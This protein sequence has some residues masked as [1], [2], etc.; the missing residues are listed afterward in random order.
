MAALTRWTDFGLKYKKYV[1]PSYNLPSP[2]GDAAPLARPFVET[3]KELRL[4]SIVVMLLDAH[5]SN[6]LLALPTLQAMSTFGYPW[7]DGTPMAIPESHNNTQLYANI[8]THLGDKVL[9]NSRVTSVHRAAN[10]TATITVKSAGGCTKIKAKQVVVGFVPTP[11]NMAPFDT[12]NE[13]AELFVKWN[14]VNLHNGFLRVDGLPDGIDFDPV[15]SDPERFFIPTAPNV[16][17]LGLSGTPYA[18]TY[19]IGN[20]GTDEAG[21]KRL[22]E[23]RLKTINAAGTFHPSTTPEYVAFSDHTPLLCSVNEAEMEAGFW[24]RVRALQGKRNTYY[25][26]QAMAADL[27]AFVWAQANEVIESLVSS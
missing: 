24:T 25:V 19:V 6:D 12:T 15:S 11:S 17:F 21:A 5:W 27:T 26:G 22:V 3:V 1:Y 2:L 14:C 9:L 4:E 13:E 20:P 10:G 18:V 7:F 16:R 23:E 8:Q